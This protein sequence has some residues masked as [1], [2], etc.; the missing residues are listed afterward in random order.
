M[1]ILETALFLVNVAWASFLLLAGPLTAALE[2]RSG[3]RLAEPRMS[4]YL[5]A[6]RSLAILATITVLVDFPG[7]GVAVR[8]LLA[9]PAPVLLLEWTLLA[10]SLCLAV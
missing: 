5:S 2:R 9:I 10:F 1:T 3:K 8:A 6:A 4:S 7:G